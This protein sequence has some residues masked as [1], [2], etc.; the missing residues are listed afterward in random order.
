MSFTARPTWKQLVLMV[1]LIVPSV[2]FFVFGYLLP[3]E[4]SGYAWGML[5]WALLS[6]GLS[7]V[8]FVLSVIFAVR[9]RTSIGWWAVSLFN[10][11]PIVWFF[12]N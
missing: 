7:L 1:V 12:M 2:A 3:V 11:V 8:C 10:L 4:E 6:L 5:V 9:N